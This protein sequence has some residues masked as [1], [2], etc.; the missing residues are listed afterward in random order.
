[1]HHMHMHIWL[2]QCSRVLR[3]YSND[4]RDPRPRGGCFS[5]PD[6]DTLPSALQTQSSTY[7]R[8][9]RFDPNKEKKERER[10]DLTRTK[11]EYRRHLSRQIRRRRRRTQQSGS[12]EDTHTPKK[13]KNLSSGRLLFTAP[14][15]QAHTRR[16][17]GFG[18]GSFFFPR[19]L[20]TGCACVCCTHTHAC[21]KSGW[22]MILDTDLNL[23]Q[24]CTGDRR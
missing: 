14:A 6:E 10:R 18:F 12:V 24:G 19:H 20:V 7:L 8:A 15:I 11:H 17:N 23:T 3:F 9:L 5:D 1:M 22:D 4:S 2:V 16:V 13:K 21:A